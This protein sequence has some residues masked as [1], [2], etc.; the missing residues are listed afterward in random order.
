MNNLQIKYLHFTNGDCGIR[1]AKLLL[2]HFKFPAEIYFYLKARFVKRMILKL[3]KSQAL[4]L[5]SI[6]CKINLYR[7]TKLSDANLWQENQF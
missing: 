4:Y 6:S 7:K 3:R 1:N 5:T 2:R